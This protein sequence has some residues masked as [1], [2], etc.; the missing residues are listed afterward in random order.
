MLEKTLELQDKI[1]L[2]PPEIKPGLILRIPNN[3]YKIIVA[4]L[5]PI[6]RDRIYRLIE[7][8]LAEYPLL[9]SGFDS[10]TL[11]ELRRDE[12][13]LHLLD[14]EEFLNI[15]NLIN[16]S[17][18]GSYSTIRRFILNNNVRKIYRNHSFFG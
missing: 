3:F 5:E 7:F 4:E 2:L 10:S 8:D 14:K 9:E 1:I 18:E 11:L 15:F 6:G 17:N 13:D 12:N 16:N